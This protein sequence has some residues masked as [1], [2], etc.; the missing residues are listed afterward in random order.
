[1]FSTFDVKMVNVVQD[2]ECFYSRL[3]GQQCG[4]G[5]L[6]S[7][8][9]QTSLTCLAVV[10]FSVHVT[11]DWPASSAGEG[12]WGALV[13]SGLVS[14]HSSCR[15]DTAQGD[16]ALL[17]YRDYVTANAT[18]RS[19]TRYMSPHQTI[20]H[21]LFDPVCLWQK[22][23]VK[24]TCKWGD[25]TSGFVS[26]IVMTASRQ[27]WRWKLCQP[28]FIAG[29]SIRYG[30]HGAVMVT[31]SAPPSLS[32]H[33]VSISTVHRPADHSSVPHSRNLL[34]QHSTTLHT[35]SLILTMSYLKFHQFLMPGG[36]RYWKC[37]YWHEH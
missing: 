17:K 21:F 37:F 3:A 22:V 23:R 18:H 11:A 2:A 4:G 1:M 26:A 14:D 36:C 13:I 29:P 15:P 34:T 30:A 16:P 25:V 12:S 5:E 6:G 10:I 28:S 20:G 33:T 7:V 24:P 9:D 35:T 31:L 8:G 32:C 27:V 19:R